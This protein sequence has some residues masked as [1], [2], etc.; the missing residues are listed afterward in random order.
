MNAFP[1]STPTMLGTESS[2]GV[3]SPGLVLLYLSSSEVRAQW[4][5]ELLEGHPRHSQLGETRS[6]FLKRAWRVRVR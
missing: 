3:S 6:F 2:L 5:W 4:F 1:L